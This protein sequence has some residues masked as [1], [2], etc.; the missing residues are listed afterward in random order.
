MTNTD[1][2]AREIAK[3]ATGWMHP[4]DSDEVIQQ[5]EDGIT[6]RIVALLSRPTPTPERDEVERVAVAISSAAY[7]AMRAQGF[8]GGWDHD[9][10]GRAIARAAIAAI[11]PPIPDRF[12]A[13]DFLA[14]YYEH[15]LVNSP[16]M[17][18]EVRRED[19]RAGSSG[20][21]LAFL[22]TLTAAH[23]AGIEEGLERA[24]GAAHPGNN[25]NWDVATARSIQFAIRSLSHRRE[26][27]G[28]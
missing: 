12:D 8:S 21:E 18:A 10:F 11:P 13:R 15:P 22:E 28:K 20:A 9:E 14:A 5:M 1:Q 4:N 27:V 3:Y 26:G 7:D 25:E 17:A 23:Q 16:S 2:K 19:W 24:A 6:E